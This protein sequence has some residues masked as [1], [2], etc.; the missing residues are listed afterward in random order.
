MSIKETV[1]TA[2]ARTA[3]NLKINSPEIL[4]GAGVILGAAAIGTTIYATVK[5]VKE[6]HKY[7]ETIR[8]LDEC[9]ENDETMTEAD[10]ADETRKATIRVIKNIVLIYA[11]P[12]LLFVGSIAAFLGGHNILKGRYTATAAA[13]ALSTEELA[14]YRERVAALVGKDK[15]ADAYYDVKEI[16]IPE[17]GDDE[18]GRPT[19]TFHR[20]TF[21]AHHN[22]Y[23][24]CFDEYNSMWSK[25]PQSNMDFLL[26]REREA[27]RLLMRL[28][29]LTLNDLR[30]MLGFAKDHFTDEQWAMGQIVG[31]T[32]NDKDFPDG[33]HQVDLGIRRYVGNNQD[34]S[35]WIN[36]NCDGVIVKLDKIK[37][38]KAG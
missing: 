13:L 38:I 11:G 34:V 27:N 15:E 23:A 21:D 18:E 29:F 2:V 9:R 37:K 19:T 33:D 8:I 4:V 14:K 22:Q 31:W 35:I 10:Y 20:Q 28:H 36:P 26:T 25:D 32:Y 7:K 12:T 5:A 1:S 6:H 17:N 16:D 30:I 24:M 3:Q